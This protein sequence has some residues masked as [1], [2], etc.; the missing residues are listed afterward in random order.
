ML[1]KGDNYLL[2]LGDTG[3]DA[4][5]KSDNL[6]KLWQV[7]APLIK[8]KNL[9]GIMIETSFP[10]EQPDKTLFGHFT[11]RW[12]MAEMTNLSNLTGKEALQGFNIIITHLK[13]PVANIEKIKLQLKTENTL[14]L[15]IIYPE[16]G[17]KLEL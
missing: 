3:P 16:Q 11:P 1:N 12:L 5:E 8:N 6:K 2:Y 14:H 13:P 4:V 10:D 15:N 17:I 9:K 7:I